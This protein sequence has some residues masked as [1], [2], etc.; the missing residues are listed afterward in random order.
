MNV[1]SGLIHLA[2][3]QHIFKSITNQDDN[4]A[5]YG[6]I[7]LFILPESTL[8]FVSLRATIASPVSNFSM[9]KSAQLSGEQQYTYTSSLPEVTRKEEIIIL[10]VY[11]LACSSE[12]AQDV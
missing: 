3:G 11:S 6:V 10:I 12:I 2:F 4:G 1:D 8:F 5:C 9:I 7:G